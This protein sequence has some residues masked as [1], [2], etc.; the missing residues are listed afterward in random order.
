LSGSPAKDRL[1]SLAEDK[2]EQ[3][4]YPVV[5]WILNCDLAESRYSQEEDTGLKHVSDDDAALSSIE[6][7]D[8]VVNLELL[9][10]FAQ[11]GTEGAST[12]M[13]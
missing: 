7:I 1:L 11:M 10:A 13:F 9:R 4:D 3:G 6:M 12:S 2:E 5:F 8:F